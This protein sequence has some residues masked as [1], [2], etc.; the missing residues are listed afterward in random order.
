MNAEPPP[1]AKKQAEPFDRARLAAAM[2][3][4]CE[5][6]KDRSQLREEPSA[7]PDTFYLHPQTRWKGTFREYDPAAAAWKYYAPCWHTGQAVKALVMAHRL[8][9]N[10]GYL[11]SARLG[12]EFL[13]DNRVTG[14]EDRG[15]LL[16]FESRPGDM[17]RVPGIFDSLLGLILFSEETGESEWW[18]VVIEALEWVL[19]KAYLPGSGRSRNFYHPAR[20]V[21]L[22][23]LQTPCPEG[24]KPSADDGIWL[25]AWRRTG[26]RR[27]RDVAIAVSE[28]LLADE[29]P[30]GNW[31]CYGPSSLEEGHDHPRQ[32]YWYG[33]PLLQVFEETGDRRFLEAT[34]RSAAWFMRAQ[35]RDGGQFRKTYHDGK[36]DCFVQ[37]TSGAACAA[38]FWMTL[39]ARFPDPSHL[40]HVRRAM[41]FFLRMQIT[42]PRDPNLLG[43]VIC[44][45]NPPDGTD[46]P[47]YRVRDL[48]AIFY[49]QA[50]AQLLADEG[51][52]A[53]VLDP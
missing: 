9:P 16:A 11:A 26:D 22:P 32:A 14:G 18:D 48:D 8:F 2:K 49:V 28:R 46:Q 37:E 24:G 6:L 34:R 35:R 12:A 38:I 17:V 21:F 52:A 50:A 7:S 44:A 40:P 13:R 31:A 39:H 15:L 42:R 41:E 29:N 20:K 36:T 30:P 19:G 47:G 1:R 4:S 43:A 45:V 5:W 10:E 23:Y 3:L 33:L 51:L 27:Y 25:R 53:Q